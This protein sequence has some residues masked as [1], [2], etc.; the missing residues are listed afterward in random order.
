MSKF[1]PL[2]VVLITLCCIG[3]FIGLIGGSLP[4][5]NSLNSKVEGPLICPNGTFKTSTDDTGLNNLTSYFCSVNGKWQDAS[6]QFV[7]LTTLIWGRRSLLYYS[8]G[9]A[10]LL[11]SGV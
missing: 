3:S 7:T 6:F 10:S 1:G 4:V 9:Q 5:F 2:M 11:L 8:S